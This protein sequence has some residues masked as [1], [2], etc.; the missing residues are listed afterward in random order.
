MIINYLIVDGFLSHNNNKALII[1]PEKNMDLQKS[2][3]NFII[4]GSDNMFS[5]DKK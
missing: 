5:L 1:I 4:I 3:S 2:R